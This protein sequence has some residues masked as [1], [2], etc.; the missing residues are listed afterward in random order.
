MKSYL[1][2]LT[3][4]R[5]YTSYIQKK[6]MLNKL[7]M[8]PMGDWWLNKWERR[9]HWTSLGVS[10]YWLWS[11]VSA[12]SEESSASPAVPC[13]P[14]ASLTLHFRQ[15]SA[16]WEPWALP[17]EP[18]WRQLFPMAGHW[19]LTLYPG[20]DSKNTSPLKVSMGVFHHREHRWQQWLKTGRYI[21]LFTAQQGRQISLAIATEGGVRGDIK[22]TR[23]RWQ[24]P[25]TPPSR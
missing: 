15:L 2:K 17:A 23:A 19:R 7:A 5:V 11:F 22:Q 3:V 12:Q 13:H 24:P 1:L 6:K 4:L 18:L 20:T 9:G 8:S 10:H 25:T 21:L 16:P 14:S